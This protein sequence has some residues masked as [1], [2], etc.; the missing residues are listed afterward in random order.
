MPNAQWYRAGR[1]AVLEGSVSLESSSLKLALLVPSHD[2]D[3]DE[4]QVFED[5]DD[6]ELDRAGY[7]AGGESITNRSFSYDSATDEH[8]FEAGDVLWDQ[9]TWTDPGVRYGVI[10][11]DG[12][13]A[14]LL[15]LVD[16]ITE[17]EPDNQVFGL[18][19]SP[20]GIARLGLPD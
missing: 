2:P 6:D 15:M 14:R 18:V 12:S 7:D 13:P 11:V 8:V 19:W 10:Y 3:L 17:R 5:V 20:D 4:H 16:F 9:V 1:K